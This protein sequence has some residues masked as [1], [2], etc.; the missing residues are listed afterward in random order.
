MFPMMRPRNWLRRET[1][2]ERDVDHFFRRFWEDLPKTEELT[3]TYP[4][5]IDED[6]KNIKVDAEMPGFKPEE[7]DVNIDNGMLY[8]TAERKKTEPQG[9][10]R[11][12]ER[13][14]TRV[15]RSFNLPSN[16][17]TEN[18][19]ASLDNGVLH[20]SIPKEETSQSKKIEVK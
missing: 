4:V 3:G 18:V 2:F 5:D 6:E 14:F 13:Q 11:V 17:K 9:K 8:I 16:A 12:S 1:P 19:E 15:E 20:L 7:I 10:R